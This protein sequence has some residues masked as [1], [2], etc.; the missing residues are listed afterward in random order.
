MKP[1]DVRSKFPAALQSIVDSLHAVDRHLEEQFATFKIRHRNLVT[2]R[3]GRRIL[4]SVTTQCI[5]PF[6]IWH[7]WRDAAV[8]DQHL[9]TTKFRLG[10]QT[11]FTQALFLSLQERD[12]TMS[13]E[14]IRHE[15]PWNELG[16]DLSFSDLSRNIQWLSDWIETDIAYAAFVSYRTNKAIFRGNKLKRFTAALATWLHGHEMLD[17]S[18]AKRWRWELDCIAKEHGQDFPDRLP[19]VTCA[20]PSV[21]SFY[22]TDAVLPIEAWLFRIWPLV[23][24]HHWTKTEI[25]GCVPERW[26]R[27]EQFEKDPDYFLRC[28]GL[29]GGASRGVH[30]ARIAPPKKELAVAWAKILS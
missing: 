20:W 26:A 22:K 15:K 3:L 7:S 27:R 13:A 28:L 4:E 19:E 23:I 17:H 8:L 10:R 24:H 9:R 18:K 12:E 29:R 5:A 16:T 25:I 21:D 6:E 14:M 11:S 30:Y 1:L 2:Q